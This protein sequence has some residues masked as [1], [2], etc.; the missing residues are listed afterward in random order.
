MKTLLRIGSLLTLLLSIPAFALLSRPNEVWQDRARAV[1]LAPALERLRA[2]PNP[3]R[4]DQHAGHFVTFD[5]IEGN[6]TIRIFN[7][8]AEHVKTISTNGSNR[9]TWDLTNESGATVASGLYLYLATSDSGDRASGK[10][11]VIR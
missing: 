10:L 9:A 5:Q 6:V 11:A 3:W 1:Q 2:Y 8:A 4:A 7:V